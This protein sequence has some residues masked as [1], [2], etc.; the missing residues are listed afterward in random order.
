M[1]QAS[2]HCVTI[3]DECMTVAA[4]AVLQHRIE[5]ETHL[6]AVARVAASHH[7]SKVDVNRSWAG[8]KHDALTELTIGRVVDACPWTGA[9]IE[10]LFEIFSG[11]AW[12][13]SSFTADGDHQPG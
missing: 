4:M 10:R 13:A 3:D 2:Q 11:E 5:G 7:L 9:E 8:K 6:D 12:F 1:L